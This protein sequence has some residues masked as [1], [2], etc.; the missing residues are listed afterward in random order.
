MKK[1][2]LAAITVLCA[3]GVKASVVQPDTI[4]KAT[5][6][7]EVVITESTSGVNYIVN[8][9]AADST[10][11]IYYTQ[12]YTPDAMVRTRQSRN[13]HLSDITAATSVGGSRWDIF[14][15]GLGL[16]MVCAPGAPAEMQLEPAKSF[17]INWLYALGVRYNIPW[18]ADVQLG[19]GFV[20]RNY[21]STVAG[22]RMVSG[23]MNVRFEPWAEG[24]T[25]CNTAIKTFA[26][27]FP[28]IYR[29]KTGVSILGNQLS[30]SAGAVLNVST[31]ASV[32][33]GWIDTSGQKVREC[34]HGVGQ[35][36]VTVDF[37]GVVGTHPVSAFVRYSP[38]NVLTGDVSPRFKSLSA[39]LM[40]L[41]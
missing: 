40:L 34:F 17:E 10:M 24:S 32:K 7:R 5:D 21:R 26:M 3:A 8:G 31:Y 36:K 41:F 27:Q 19:M 12:L 13:F 35:R 18:N 25:G 6:V 37:I 11:T 22:L 16:G 23:D 2:I 14:L 4:I 29:Q 30:V 38:Q 39:G 15:A 20:W 33:N 1:Y 28:L 9:T